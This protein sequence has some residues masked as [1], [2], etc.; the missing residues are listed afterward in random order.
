MIG[1]GE[2]PSSLRDQI[3]TRVFDEHGA[4]DAVHSGLSGD[5]ETLGGFGD[6]KSVV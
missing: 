5:P 2:D 4:I 1:R 3:F 6:R